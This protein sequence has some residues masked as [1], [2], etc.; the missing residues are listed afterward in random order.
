M[1]GTMNHEISES[2]GGVEWVM[3]LMKL[4]MMWMVAKGSHHEIFQ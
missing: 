3:V 1:A 4:G 2:K